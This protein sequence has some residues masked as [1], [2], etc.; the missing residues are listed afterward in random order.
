[1][2]KNKNPFIYKGFNKKKKNKKNLYKIKC[3]KYLYIK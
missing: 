2:K 3:I 1:M